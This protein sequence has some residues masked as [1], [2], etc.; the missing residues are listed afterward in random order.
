MFD[1]TVGSVLGGCLCG[2]KIKQKPEYSIDL[3]SIYWEETFIFLC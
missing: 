1:K 2:T 3:K